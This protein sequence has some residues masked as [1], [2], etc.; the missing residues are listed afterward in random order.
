MLEDCFSTRRRSI[1]V[2][3]K[4]LCTIGG[5]EKESGRGDAD[6]WHEN[7]EEMQCRMRR[8]FRLYVYVVSN[9]GADKSVCDTEAM[10]GGSRCERCV[11]CKCHSRNM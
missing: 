6:W 11:F 10:D 8:R 2:G 1:R 3:H 7:F 5:T 4:H 9:E